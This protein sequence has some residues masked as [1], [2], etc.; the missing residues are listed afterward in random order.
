MPCKLVPQL[1][2]CKC[3]P[4]LV[5][6]LV[7]LLLIFISILFLHFFFQPNSY[8]SFPYDPI[9]INFFFIFQTSPTL[10]L[11]YI[12]SPSHLFPNPVPLCSIS[13]FPIPIFKERIKN[14]LH[15]ASKRSRDRS[16]TLHQ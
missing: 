14:A 2:R 13:S 5:T 11:V 10:F 1:M 4:L 9:S 16:V 3:P 8:L 12:V 7:F 6:S 15:V